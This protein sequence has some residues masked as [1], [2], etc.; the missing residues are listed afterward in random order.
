MEELLRAEE[1]AATPVRVRR[2]RR[3]LPATLSK[4]GRKAAPFAFA[5]TTVPGFVF[6]CWLS[7]NGRPHGL[8]AMG[9]TQ[10]TKKKEP[11][12]RESFSCPAAI[13]VSLCRAKVRCSSSPC[14]HQ[15]PESFSG[16][17]RFAVN[18]RPKSLAALLTQLKKQSAANPH[19]TSI[20]EIRPTGLWRPFKFESPGEGRGLFRVSVSRGGSQ[21][22]A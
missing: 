19:G 1:A 2:C 8:A 16:R 15:F 22:N 5:P 21:F 13:T 10:R 12:R 9:S 17:P 14:I 4:A 6:W 3:H 7:G 20:K 11:Q 18:P